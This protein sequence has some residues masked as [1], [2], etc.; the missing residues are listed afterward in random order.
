M[1]APLNT[2]DPLPLKKS[3]AAFQ[4]QSP[5]TRPLTQASPLPPY[6]NDGL[7]G[8]LPYV[9]E[10][11]PLPPITPTFAS[12]LPKNVEEA[13]ALSL[14]VE[15][16]LALGHLGLSDSLACVA[17]IVRLEH[18]VQDLKDQRRP[19]WSLLAAVVI[20][21]L[22]GTIAIGAVSGR[23]ADLESGPITSSA[24]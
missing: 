17:K 14:D 6:H 23:I 11:R 16:I 9:Q 8:R 4:H 2:P 3:G 7:K 22:A 13:E 1:S 20:F 18:Q 5:V 12:P 24:D 10:R 21:I 15:S 19:Y